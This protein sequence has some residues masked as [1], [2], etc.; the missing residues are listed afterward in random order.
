MGCW[1]GP[2]M[3]LACLLLL[4]PLPSP[5]CPATC[6]CSSGQVD[7]SQRAFREVPPSLASN[8]SALW[9][10]YNFITVL[11]PH[12]FPVLSR[13]LLLSLSHNLLELIHSQAL[14][15]LKALQELDLSHNY[16][17]VL[18]R[19][20]FEPL[21]SLAMLHLGSNRLGVLEPGVLDV[22]PQLQALTL[23]D[24]PWVCSCGILPLWRWLSYNREKVREK[25]LLLC[26]VPEELN[27][28]PIMAFGNESFRQCQETSL[29]AQ[30]YITFLII[31]PFSF[32]ASII[33]C[34]LLGSITVVYNNLRREP[35]FWR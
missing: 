27:K 10:R 12:S 21:T 1:Q 6:R 14:V 17:T 18:S 32:M 26:R 4:C 20:T 16:L 2:I 30:H 8:T 9:L 5:A 3:V 33:F 22:L 23:Q 25:S 19:E 28:Y 7:C 24:N 29:S 31:G 13:L 11:G 35:H 15:G 34:M